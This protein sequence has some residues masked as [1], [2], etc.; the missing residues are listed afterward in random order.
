MVIKRTIACEVGGAAGIHPVEIDT[1]ASPTSADDDARIPTAIAAA[2][3][4][5]IQ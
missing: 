4:L 5:R 2:A 3:V 1:A